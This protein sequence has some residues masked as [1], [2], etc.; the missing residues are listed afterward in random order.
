MRFLVVE[1]GLNF[2]NVRLPPSCFSR[3]VNRGLREGV[4]FIQVPFT[5]RYT[6]NYI[7]LLN[8]K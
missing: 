7:D 8:L 6:G 5:E 1:R 4:V 2:F 3:V